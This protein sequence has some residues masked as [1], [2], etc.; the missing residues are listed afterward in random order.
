[1]GR[2][3]DEDLRDRVV[4]V[5][6]SG[7]GLG[8]AVVRAC[9][10]RRARVVINCRSDRR[11]AEALAVEVCRPG[12]TEALVC[13]A[14]VTDPEQARSL[15]DETLQS[16]GRLD[17]LV[18]AV[19]LFAW[20]PVAELEPAE[21]RAVMGSNLDSVYNMCRLALPHMRRNHW[22][23]IVNLGAVG[24]ERALGQPKVS[25]YSAAKAGVI[26]F[27]KALALEEARCGITVNV[28]SPGVLGDGAVV[29]DVDHAGD[30]VPVGRIG[31][32]EDVLRAVMFFLSPSAG[33]VTGQV[34]A[35]AGG[36]R[37]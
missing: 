29:G 9:V 18:N 7:R 8:A 13:R 24:A 4:L 15:V 37:L 20:K 21:W 17:V 30:R 11:A 14:D 26:A 3:G 25:A 23:R 2:V 16:Y 31:G 35:V 27:S 28:V 22:G 12:G 36:W 33:Y 5:T 19:G 10:E 32:A 6:G 34:L 1:M